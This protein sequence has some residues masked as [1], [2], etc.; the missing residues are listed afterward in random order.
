M[1]RLWLNLSVF[2][3]TIILAFLFFMAVSPLAKANAVSEVDGEAAVET[4]LAALK[5][6]VQLDLE[7]KIQTYVD[8]VACMENASCSEA[9]EILTKY[10]EY[11]IYVGLIQYQDLAMRMQQMGHGYIVHAGVRLYF[12]VRNDEGREEFELIQRLHEED[13]VATGRTL[14][15][16]NL[17]DDTR[18]YRDVLGNLNRGGRSHYSA[19]VSEYLAAYPFF[20]RSRAQSLTRTT[21]IEEIEDNGREFEE[22]MDNI[23]GLEGTERFELMGFTEALQ[24]AVTRLSTEESEVVAEYI[25]AMNNETRLWGKIKKIFTS[26]KTLAL[27]TCH[28]TTFALAAVPHPVVQ[29]GRLAAGFICSSIG[30]TITIRHLGESTADI[31]RQTA[32]AATGAYSTEI[33][34]QYIRSYFTTLVMSMIYVVPSLPGLKSRAI[35]I[36]QNGAV[37]G[38][39]YR[40]NKLNLR[41]R[42]RDLRFDRNNFHTDVR[43]LGRS[44]A[45]YYGEELAVNALLTAGGHYSNAVNSL[46]NL[47]SVHQFQAN[48]GSVIVLPFAALLN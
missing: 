2:K 16:M 5:S 13:T 23:E 39:A 25:Q 6:E 24:K 27:A 43:T 7:Q 4:F 42:G 14:A 18:E 48:A 46:R 38:R 10:R 31:I 20:G 41:L 22:V 17:T 35:G 9:D 3:R 28:I 30:L 29:I 47:I 8:L 12:T 32:Y 15:G 40:M 11:R 26:W 45:Q 44:Y 21:A 34:S 33:L 37:I 19:S 36:G 1:V